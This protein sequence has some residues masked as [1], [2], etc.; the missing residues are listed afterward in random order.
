MQ[1]MRLLL[2]GLAVLILASLLVAC[3]QSS[4]S[5]PRA[6]STPSVSSMSIEDCTDYMLDEVLWEDAP[7]YISVCIDD[8]IG[9]REECARIVRESLGEAAREWCIENR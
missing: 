4:P 8:G 7:A 2:L 9:D 3:G 5:R 1:R 6:T